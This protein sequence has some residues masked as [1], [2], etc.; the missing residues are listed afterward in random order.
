MDETREPF[1]GRFAPDDEDDA[2][3]VRPYAVTGGRTTTSSAQMPVEALVQGMSPTDVGMTPERRTILEL[4]ANQYLS[5]AELSA[6]IKLPIGVMRVLV[7]D[8]AD[9]GKI[10]VHGLTTTDHPGSPAYNP[11]ASLSVLE[12]VLNGISAL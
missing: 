2:S 3:T 4:T 10:R 7:S 5:V 8:L 12:S 11:A 6:H 9:E 1:G